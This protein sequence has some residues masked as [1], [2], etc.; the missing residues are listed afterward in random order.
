MTGV[1][2]NDSVLKRIGKRFRKTTPL[3]KFSSDNTLLNISAAQANYALNIHNSPT[4][5]IVPSKLFKILASEG[6]LMEKPGVK[7]TEI[8]TYQR[9]GLKGTDLDVYTPGEI[10]ETK[11]DRTGRRLR[12]LEEMNPDLIL[13]TGK[14]LKKMM[15]YNVL[16]VSK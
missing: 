12:G 8:G 14:R 10:Y 11:S 9:Y 6:L 2:D 16:P 4:S 5:A 1:I 15:P 7:K 3:K 13:C